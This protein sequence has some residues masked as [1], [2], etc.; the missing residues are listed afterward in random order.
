MDRGDRAL[1]AQVRPARQYCHYPGPRSFWC[2]Y[3]PAPSPAGVNQRLGRNRIGIVICAGFT[4]KSAAA[5]L[6]HASNTRVATTG[7]A[8]RNGAGGCQSFEVPTVPAANNFRLVRSEAMPH[9][10]TLTADWLNRCAQWASQI[11]VGVP[12]RTGFR[13]L[14]GHSTAARFNHTPSQCKKTP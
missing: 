4:L 11:G 13:P 14:L 2:L 6:R 5:P 12:V 3:R 10:A 1:S 7:T 9:L 8:D